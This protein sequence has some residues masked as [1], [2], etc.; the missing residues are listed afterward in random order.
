MVG[1]AA[2][3]LSLL[4]LSPPLSQERERTLDKVHDLN[5]LNMAQSGLSLPLF[6]SLLS[7]PRH[8]TCSVWPRAWHHQ[9]SSLSLPLS[10]ICAYM[11]GFG[12]ISRERK[13]QNERKT[14]SPL[15]LLKTPKKKKKTFLRQKDKTR[16]N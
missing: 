3:A 4:S 8:D 13:R 6:A 16:H 14:G 7:L 5:I 1:E 12:Q 2:A 9:L 11:A 15:F 10:L